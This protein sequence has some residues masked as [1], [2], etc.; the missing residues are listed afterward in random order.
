MLV[1]KAVFATALTLL[2][3][4]SNLT[5]PS[6]A[7]SPAKPNAQINSNTEEEL[8]R[9]IRELKQ[10]QEAIQKELQEIKRLL[11]AKEG[12]AARP[13]RPDKMS[14]SS[15]PFRGSES[16]RVVMV[17]FSDYQC[18]FCGRFFRD[19]L[20]LLD[21]EYIDSGRIK[22]VYNHLPLDDLH[23]AAFKAALSVECAGDQGKFWDLHRR[24][25]ANQSLLASGDVASQ[26]RAIGLDMNQF[27]RCMQGDKAEAAVRSGVTEAGALGIEATPT[28]V[29]GLADA[30]NPNDPNIKILAVIGGAY[31]FAVFKSAID[32]ALATQ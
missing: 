9:D 24:L 6:L 13:A 26:A 32:K 20:P 16:A 25:F 23:P 18:P 14:I 7:Q 1:S 27:D 2:I 8:R 3:T 12:A 19:T 29:I 17:E 28:F 10:G 15:R 31:P 30:K 11:L 4:G 22:Y 5:G 21:K